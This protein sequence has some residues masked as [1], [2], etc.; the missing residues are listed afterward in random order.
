MLVPAVDPSYSYDAEE[1]ESST[2][3]LM[4]L[5]NVLHVMNLQ[6][7]RMAWMTRNWRW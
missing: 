4:Q 2:A 6:Q 1:L 3:E 5:L 7:A